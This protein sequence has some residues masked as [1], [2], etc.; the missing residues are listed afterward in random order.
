[1]NDKFLTWEEAVIWLRN[2]PDKSDLVTDCFYDEP[3]MKAAD[4]FYHSSEWA[5]IQKKLQGKK[6]IVLDIGAG[7]GISSFAFAR[8]GWNVVSVEPDSSTIVGTRA[9]KTLAKD[10]DISIAVI[11]T[12]AESLP[13]KDN[14]FDAV[15]GRQVLH[16]ARDLLKM[17][18]EIARVLKP[19]GIIIITREHVL[20]H[21]NDLPTFLTNHP[22]HRYYGGEH[23]YRL[24]Q[25]RE[26]LVNSGI[27]IERILG[28]HSSDINMFPVTTYEIK[29]RIAKKLHLPS[30]Y[31]PDILLKIMDFFDNTPGRLYSF[32]GRKFS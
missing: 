11:Q 1:M 2:Q 5:E 29:E 28:P 17:C 14:S 21:D 25:Y 13:F 3:I 30:R 32:I 16:H 26:V 10:S 23:A 22:L 18:N 4:R 9:I 8:D 20:S 6:G 31:I 27:F 19:N 24:T 7:R 12:F 15:Y